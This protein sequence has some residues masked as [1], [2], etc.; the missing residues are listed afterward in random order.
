MQIDDDVIDRVF[1]YQSLV[2][3]V[4]ELKYPVH[5]KEIRTIKYALVKF[6][7]HLLGTEPVAV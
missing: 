1:L 3:K 7:M 4:A 2:L 5:D 6:Q